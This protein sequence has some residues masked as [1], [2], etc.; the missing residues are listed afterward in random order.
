MNLLVVDDSAV[1]RSIV[2]KSLKMSG[3]PIDSLVEACNG[4][5]ALEKLDQHWID[6]AL[7]DINMPVMNGLEL[8]EAVRASEDCADLPIIVVSTESGESRIQGFRE[9]GLGFVH[10]PF[11]PQELR[12]EIEGV[13]GVRFQDDSEGSFDESGD[14]DF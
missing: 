5:D 12:S 14:L 13:T 8:I 10:K 3:V 9:Q 2:V 6:C 7:V 1:M 4:K 11:G